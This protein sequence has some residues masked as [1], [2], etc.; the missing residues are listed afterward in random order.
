[1]TREVLRLPVK[2]P[3]LYEMKA[4]KYHADPCPV[5][6]LN[7]TVARI[8]TEQSPMHAYKAHP[9]LGGEESE[10][11]RIMDIGTAAHRLA[12]GRGTPIVR[13][14]FEN[15]R[16]KA[17]QEA[18][19]FYA[20]RGHAALLAPDYDRAEAMAKPLRAAIED[21]AGCNIKKLHREIV[22]IACDDNV[23]SRCMIDVMSPD[24][25]LLLDVKTTANAHP[26]KYTRTIRDYSA[27][28]VAFYFQTLDLIDPEG[29][30]KR[31]FVFIAQERECEEAITYHELS[32]EALAVADAKMRRARLAWKVASVTNSWPGYPR[33]PHIVEPNQWD[34]DTELAAAFEAQAMG[35]AI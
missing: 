5:P 9:R 35:G 15:F 4:E 13:L 27:T 26:D 12:I 7:H 22:A 31:R 20:A 14:E 6:S 19:D 33:G 11:T 3:G 16:T 1:M 28:A 23:W 34:L 8:L 24:L 2:G 10:P 17:A 25:R 30:G 29:A 32:P 18:R 21:V